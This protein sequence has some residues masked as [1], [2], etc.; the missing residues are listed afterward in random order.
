MAQQH[1]TDRP[2]QQPGLIHALRVQHAMLADAKTVDTIERYSKPLAAALAV[3]QPLTSNGQVRR[4]CA[5]GQRPALTCC[6][7]QSAA[8][9]L[10][11]VMIDGR[12][13]GLS[14]SMHMLHG[15][16]HWRWRMCCWT[17][18]TAKRGVTGAC[19]RQL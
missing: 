12:L 19:S 16:T 17:V 13:R 2:A 9:N 6:L 7:G 5:A 14:S 18:P 10:Q 8:L 1:C 4:S 11:S 15:G 3:T